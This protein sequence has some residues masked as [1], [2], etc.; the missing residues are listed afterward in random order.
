MFEQLPMIQ[1]LILLRTDGLDN[2]IG[3]AAMAS[4][5]AWSL[6]DQANSSGREIGWNGSESMAC[7]VVGTVGPELIPNG[8]QY[9]EAR[10]TNDKERWQQAVKKEGH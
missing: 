8:V 1:R 9:E 10:K 4:N 3:A 2:D 7:C 6:Q 5:I